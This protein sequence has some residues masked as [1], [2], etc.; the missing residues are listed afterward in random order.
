MNDE[1]RRKKVEIRCT[2]TT[3]LIMQTMIITL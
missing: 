1:S 3:P 2:Q